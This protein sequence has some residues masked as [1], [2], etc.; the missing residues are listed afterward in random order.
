MRITDN[1][2]YILA[3]GKLAIMESKIAYFS[4]DRIYDILH[5]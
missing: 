3:L 5:F 4:Y 1:I 2:V